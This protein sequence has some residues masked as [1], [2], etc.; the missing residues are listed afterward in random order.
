MCIF[1]LIFGLLKVR[2]DRAIFLQKSEEYLEK[3]KEFAKQVGI[4]NSSNNN[5]NSNIELNEDVEKELLRDSENVYKQ[6]D[7][8]DPNPNSFKYKS[9]RFNLEHPLDVL[10]V[11]LLIG[12][13][14]LFIITR[15][16][17]INSIDDTSE[18]L[19]CIG[20]N[21]FY[22]GQLLN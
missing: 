5:D 1:G 18:F 19:F 17:L 4:D 8:S 13:G 21:M 15:F 7:D 9:F 14:L 11:L 16:F 20:I 2:R 6:L 22:C 12:S 3:E 10:S